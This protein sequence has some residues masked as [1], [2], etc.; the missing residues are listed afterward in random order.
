M[1]YSIE[2]VFDQA[3]NDDYAVSMTGYS[4]ESH[5]VYGIKIIKD[6]SNKEIKLFDTM[7][8]GDYFVPLT[9]REVEIFLENGWRYGVYVLS[10]DNYRTKLD[11]IEQRIQKCIAEKKSSKQISIQKSSRERILKKY[12]EINLKLNQ[13]NY[14]NSKEKADNI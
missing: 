14:G 5:M 4:F 7:K 12:S 1:A 2:E 8:R 9:K 6:T 3:S 13:L 10:L 11:K